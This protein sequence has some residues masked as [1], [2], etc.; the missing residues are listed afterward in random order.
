MNRMQELFQKKRSNIC[1]VYCTAGFPQLESPLPVMKAL[2]DNGVDM[3]EL[4]MPYSDPLAD[5]PVIQASGTK[6]LQN[7]MTITKL[8]GQLK[9]FRKEISVPVVLMGYLNP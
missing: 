6:A 4:G 7:G 1:N 2:Q 8:F 9:E 5:G 3:I